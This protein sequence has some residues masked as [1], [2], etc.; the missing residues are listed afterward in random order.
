MRARRLVSWGLLALAALSVF[1]F[2]I[3][4]EILFWHP[5][6]QGL[7]LGVVAICLLVASR[8]LLRG[9]LR[10]V[11]WVALGVLGAFCAVEAHDLWLHR[12][13]R[14]AADAAGVALSWRPFTTL[15]LEQR[16]YVT[17]VAGLGPRPL[18]ILHVTDLHI[19][20]DLPAEYYLRIQAA[21]RAANPDVIALTGDL[22]SQSERVP[23]LERWLDTLPRAPLGNFAVLG[24]HEYWAH[25]EDSVRRALQRSDV[26]LLTGECAPIA[27]YRL[28]ICG[29]DAPWGAGL[30]ASA[31]AR[32][33]EPFIALSHTPDNVYDL[34]ALGASVV[35]AGHTHGG[36]A[37]LPWFGPIII[38]SRYGRRFDL[39]HFRV[40]NTDLFV[41]AGVGADSPP[42]R[43]GCPPELLE[44]ELRDR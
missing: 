15:D 5:R 38:P 6:Y 23:L 1:V 21:L 4:R 35:L 40:G 37:R 10:N 28:Q 16:R 17:T 14:A 43:I 36:Q 29:T 42:L 9:A 33:G 13:Y 2:A 20:E 8:W 12:Q 24:N 44:L 27:G 30:A 39:G 34:A 11:A 18:R 31:P 32:R 3:N 22:V 26:T 25:A 41:S 7:G 19:T